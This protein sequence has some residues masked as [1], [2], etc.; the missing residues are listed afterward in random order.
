[1][2]PNSI[3]GITLIPASSTDKEGASSTLSVKTLPSTLTN[4]TLTN[5]T[6]SGARVNWTGSGYTKVIVTWTGGG[7]SGYILSDG[8]LPTSGSTT[9]VWPKRNMPLEGSSTRRLCVLYDSSD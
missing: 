8:S 2:V 7:S 6:T 5:V 9:L 1:M 3:S 4:L